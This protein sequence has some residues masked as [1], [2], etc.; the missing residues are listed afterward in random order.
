VIS[1]DW[2]DYAEICDFCARV[3]ITVCFLTLLEANIR[4][5]PTLRAGES[6]QDKK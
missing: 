1:S 5:V 3:E 4:A 6:L 2:T